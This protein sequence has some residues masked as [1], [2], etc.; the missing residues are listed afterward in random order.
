MSEL[1]A[2]ERNA[3]EWGQFWR[4]AAG[5]AIGA[6]LLVGTFIGVLGGIVAMAMVADGRIGLW[7]W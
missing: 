6:V 7:P 2:E 3:L 5:F 1:S 4:T